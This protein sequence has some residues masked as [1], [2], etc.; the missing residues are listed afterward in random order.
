[1][2]SFLPYIVQWH[3]TARAVLR[4]LSPTIPI[5]RRRQITD[6]ILWMQA[7][8]EQ[9]PETAGEIYKSRG[10]ISEYTFAKNMVVLDV[11]V[12]SKRGFVAVRKLTIMSGREDL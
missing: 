8:L 10:P 3:P 4:Q 9:A 6:A 12:D 2:S 11:A 1:M 5:H 7:R